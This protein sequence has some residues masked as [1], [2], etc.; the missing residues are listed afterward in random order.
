MG[1]YLE[2][3]EV[4]VHA[5]LKANGKVISNNKISDMQHGKGKMYDKNGNIWLEGEFVNNR[6]IFYL[7]SFQ[8]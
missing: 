3:K 7:I 1:D 8:I 4:G 2:N 6:F 5:M